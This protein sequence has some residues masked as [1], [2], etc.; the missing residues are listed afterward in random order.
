MKNLINYIRK[1]KGG[2]LCITT[3]ILMVTAKDAAIL[4]DHIMVEDLAVTTL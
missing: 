4:L 1:Q 3:E 2:C